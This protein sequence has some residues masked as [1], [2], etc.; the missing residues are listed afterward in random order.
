MTERWM[1]VPKKSIQLFENILKDSGHTSDSGVANTSG[2]GVLS[3]EEFGNSELPDCLLDP[4]SQNVLLLCIDQKQSQ[5]KATHFLV[6]IGGPN[7]F[8]TFRGDCYHR[9]WRDFVYA[10]NHSYGYFHHTA[11]QLN[12]AFNVNYQPHISIRRQR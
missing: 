7:I 1:Q 6:D 4:D 3:D 12:F 10:M 9:S 8:A 2:S 5:W 11:V